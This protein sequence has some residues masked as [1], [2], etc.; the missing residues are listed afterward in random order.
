MLDLD[1]LDWST[2]GRGRRRGAD[3]LDY[4]L[5]SPGLFAEVPPFAVGRTVWDNWLVWKARDEGALVVDAS[6]TVDAIH[7]DHSYAHVG[8][9]GKVRVSP[10]AEENRRLAGGKLHLY[11][12]FDATHRLTV[13]DR[14]EAATS[15]V[16]R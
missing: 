10:E 7:Q 14:P 3:A 13:S 6:S 5:F 11:S 12:R 15:L 8:S 4:F 16:E 2:L 1:H 9:L